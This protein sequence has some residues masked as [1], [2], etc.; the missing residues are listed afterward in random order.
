V[1][2][3]PGGGVLVANWNT[4]V[5]HF[6]APGSTGPTT[7]LGH[8]GLQRGCFRSPGALSIVPEVGLVVREVRRIQVFPCKLVLSVA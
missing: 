3:C 1:L 8:T 7:P 2:P 4:D 6:V 5:V